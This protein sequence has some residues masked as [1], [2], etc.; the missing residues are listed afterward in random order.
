MAIWTVIGYWDDSDV[1]RV[2]GVV[3]GEVEVT[4]GDHASEGGPF[5]VVVDASN[6]DMAEQMVE[7]YGGEV[8]F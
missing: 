7:G 6:S 8:E 1:R 2:V 3:E 4:G 5:A